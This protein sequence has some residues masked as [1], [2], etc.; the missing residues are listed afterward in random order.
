MKVSSLHSLLDKHIRTLS[1]AIGERHAGK[2]DAL[3][4]AKQYIEDEFK[5][6]NLAVT[7]HRYEFE[8]IEFANIE[9]VLPGADK[10]EVIIVGAH[11]DSERGTPGANDNASGIAAMLAIAHDLKDY[12]ALRTIKFVA[13]ANEEAPFFGWEG[14]GSLRYAREAKQNGVNIVGMLALETLGYFTAGVGS[15]RY[16]AGMDSSALPE[17]GNFIAFVSEPGS[18]ALLAKLK[19]LFP[20]FSS[21]PCESLCA[22][23]EQISHVALSDHRSFYKE[24]YPA[25]MVTDTAPFRYPYYHDKNDTPDKLNMKVYKEVVL[26]LTACV[27]ALAGKAGLEREID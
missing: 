21:V 7:L 1:M 26:G 24:G 5:A 10:D 14:M 23:E 16:P 19:N 20:L 25:L 13:F 18:E 11:Y 4:R 3:N 27:G 22:P 12:K 8:G 17:E 2:L 15:Q 9:A 6:L